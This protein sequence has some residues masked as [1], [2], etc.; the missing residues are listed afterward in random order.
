MGVTLPLYEMAQDGEDDDEE[1]EV[2]ES[3]T[4]DVAADVT[5]GPEHCK[6]HVHI[7]NTK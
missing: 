5:F 4:I 6:S 2:D 3:G 1:E 7:Q